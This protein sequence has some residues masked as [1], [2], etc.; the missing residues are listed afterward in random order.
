MVN[1]M[2]ELLKYLT[3]ALSL[4]L[5]FSCSDKKI[6]KKEECGNIPNNM[7]SE[8]N[9]KIS[10]SM[11]IGYSNK[12]IF[13]RREIEKKTIKDS[14]HFFELQQENAEV[15]PF[16]LPI[17]QEFEFLSTPSFATNPL[18]GIEEMVF[19][20]ILKSQKRKVSKI[21]ISRKI[22]DKWSYPKSISNEVNES[23][24][25][26]NPTFS[27]DGNFII[28]SSERK[29]GFGE[30]DL[31]IINRN[32]DGSWTYPLN[33]GSEINSKGK[34]DAPYISST[35]DLFFAS[36]TETA[37]KDYDI[38]KA[39]L[40][41]NM[42]VE[43]QAL[44]YPLNSPQDDFGIAIN[45][46]SIFISSNRQG[47]CGDY[48]LYAFS[49]CSP[50]LIE[51][52]ISFEQVPLPLEG[53]AYLYDASG[54]LLGERRV[55]ANGIFRFEVAAGNDYMIKYINDC[56]TDYEPV[57]YLTTPCDMDRVV[58]MIARFMMPEEQIEFSFKEYKVPFFSSGYYLPNTKEN[59]ADLRKKFAYNFLGNADSTK[60]ID[61][62]GSEYDE[63]AIDVDNALSKAVDFIVHKIDNISEMC[64]LSQTKLKITV[65]GYADPR[66]FSPGA[67]YYGDNL[68]DELF[69]VRV[70][71]GSAMNNELISKLRAYFT[72]RHIEKEVAKK[73]NKSEMSKLLK[74]EI[75]GKGAD[76][77]SQSVDE[78]KRRVNIKV[79]LAK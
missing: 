38:F 14:F 56:L 30:S 25:S 76:N 19:S 75:I 49:L 53:T 13:R 45:D 5:L 74:W 21:L 50:V 40:D 23:Y 70:I 11:P 41:G 79:N 12:L 6:I 59:L 8:F 63:F 31:Y 26:T 44:P 33:L 77:K 37:N 73:I 46:N 4:M 29:E 32:E 72:A 17:T 10:E 34:E 47:G 66:G 48:D 67:R 57:Q 15:L 68:N 3:F 78:M 20:G 60:Y 36:N 22:N 27:P 61:Y 35:G 28:Y 42:W 55:D 69:G 62:P 51:G 71:Q 24:F 39:P 16:E 64:A 54:Y 43:K 18:N 9:S 1:R 52:Y 65:T 2:N 58:K 7:G